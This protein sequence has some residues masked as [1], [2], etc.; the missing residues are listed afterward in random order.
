VDQEAGAE[1][2]TRGA[3]IAYSVHRFFTHAC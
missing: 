2:I 1:L 3:G